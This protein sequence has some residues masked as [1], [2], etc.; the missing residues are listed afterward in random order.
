MP[1]ILA[2]LFT[3]WLVALLV[4]CTSADK[5]YNAADAKLHYF[6]NRRARLA[7]VAISQ[8]ASRCVGHRGL[9]R[10][11][12]VK[13]TSPRGYTVVTLDELYRLVI[14]ELHL[15]TLVVVECGDGTAQAEPSGVLLA[16]WQPL[17]I[18]EARVA[19]GATL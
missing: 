13:A 3:A 10:V 14:G 2:L 4:S 11:I 1:A 12:L 16:K 5:T 17:L 9:H 6:A 19:G 15:R 7:A 18:Q 8:Y